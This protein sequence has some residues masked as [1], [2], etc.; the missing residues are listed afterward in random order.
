MFSDMADALL[1]AI[2]P[3][4]RAQANDHGMSVL[5]PLPHS[6]NPATWSTD[7]VLWLKHT[8]ENFTMKWVAGIAT[9]EFYPYY[10]G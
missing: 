3:P 9:N 10:F 5:H 7:P 6:P 8:H 4:K 1:N 2:R